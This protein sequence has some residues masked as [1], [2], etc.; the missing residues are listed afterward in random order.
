[1]NDAPPKNCDSSD[2]ETLPLV[3]RG[4]MSA[5]QD[6]D[7]K[8]RS[9]RGGAS[10][11]LSQ[12]V[13]II[14]QFGTTIILARILMPSDYG[15]QA[16]VLSVT[17]FLSLFKEAGLSAASVQRKT[18]SRHEI[19]TLFWI[20]VAIGGLLT[21]LTALI[22]PALVS[23]YNDERLYGITLLSSTVFTINALSIQHRALLDRTMQFTTNNY[24]DVI[25]AIVGSIAAVWSASI[26]WGYWALIVQNVSLPLVTVIAS[27]IAM[28]WIPGRPRWTPALKEML[29]FGGT[30]TLNSVV[31]YIGYNAE[32]FLLG[33]FWGSGPLGLYGRAYQ[34]ANVPMQQLSNSVG[35][36]AFPALSRLQED[37]DRLCRFYL[38]AHSLVVSITVPVVLGVALFAEDIITTV[39]GPRWDGAAPILRLLSPAILFFALINPLSWLLR[40]LGMVS[41]SMHI[42]LVICPVMILG[43]LTGLKHGPQ[44]VALGYSSA[45]ILLAVPVL[46]WALHGTG[47]SLLDYWR[48]I[49]PPLVAGVVGGGAALLAHRVASHSLSGGLLLVSVILVDTC[50]YMLMILYAMRQKG[51]YIDVLRQLRSRVK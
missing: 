3:L 16:M 19:S 14:L 12:G 26:G 11:L 21:I 24:I 51:L 7:F 40:A 1:M 42:A 48:A 46:A 44:G 35:S 18:I 20:N 9:V 30:V 10:A 41:R 31:V 13:S 5:A 39:L 33:H 25:S 8:R 34:L 28:P 38:K 43:I 45:L 49:C 22:A 27:W 37:R 50:V 32:K 2:M 36:V 17:G 15:L 4:K 23:F 47:V 29:Q 6:E